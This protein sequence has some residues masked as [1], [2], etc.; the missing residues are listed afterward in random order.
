MGWVLRRTHSAITNQRN[1][2][3]GS[4]EPA[5]FLITEEV[6]IVSYQTP[7]C[8]SCESPLQRDIMYGGLRFYVCR[9]CGAWAVPYPPGQEPNESTAGDHDE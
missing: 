4:D 2:P 3:V 5:G 8:Q 7:Q 9:G 1:L 6:P